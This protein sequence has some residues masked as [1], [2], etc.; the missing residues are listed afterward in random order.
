[1]INTIVSLKCSVCVYNITFSTSIDPSQHYKKEM[2]K[3]NTGRK[4]AIYSY[5]GHMLN[6]IEHI[7]TR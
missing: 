7:S 3:V 4:A 5:S 2:R 1:M 6:G